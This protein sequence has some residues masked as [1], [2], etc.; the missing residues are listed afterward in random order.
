MSGPGGGETPKPGSLVDQRVSEPAT[1]ERAH[2]VY[3]AQRRYGFEERVA[4]RLAFTRWRYRSGRFVVCPP[5]GAPA[6]P[7]MHS[8]D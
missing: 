4:R 8:R 6:G 5:A 3:V 7:P 1:T 2:W